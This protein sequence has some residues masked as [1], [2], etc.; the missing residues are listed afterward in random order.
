MSFIA[1]LGIAAY[2]AMGY[3]C[4]RAIVCLR[5]DADGYWPENKVRKAAEFAV[6]LALWPLCLGAAVI[7]LYLSILG[8]RT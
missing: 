6:G 1:I 3:V 2:L 5:S 8:E 7:G 4:G